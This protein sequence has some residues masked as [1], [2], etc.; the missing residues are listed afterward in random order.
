MVDDGSGSVIVP[1]NPDNRIEAT[2]VRENIQLP[3]KLPGLSFMYLLIVIYS[4][5]NLP[6]LL[7]MLKWLKRYATL[8][9]NKRT[10][11]TT[12]ASDMHLCVKYLQ[13]TV[14][15]SGM[16]QLWGSLT[17]PSSSQ[18]WKSPLSSHWDSECFVM[19]QIRKNYFDAALCSLWRLLNCSPSTF[20]GQPFFCC[21]FLSSV[22][23]QPT[24]DLPGL[25]LQVSISLKK[26]RL[27]LQCWIY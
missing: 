5:Q 4:L 24:G 22:W 17:T 9:T 1:T 20:Y 12:R 27:I 23:A 18:R 25:R 7:H 26:K 16:I 2:V 8:Y 21:S 14:N 3:R 19:G 10:R 11:L 13:S 6:K 15:N